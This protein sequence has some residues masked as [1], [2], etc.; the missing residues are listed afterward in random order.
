MLA[1][2]RVATRRNMN[3]HVEDCRKQVQT[4]LKGMKKPDRSWQ[5]ELRLRIDAGHPV[6]VAVQDLLDRAEGRKSGIIT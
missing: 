5:T 4:F 6:S 1:P 3:N 2:S